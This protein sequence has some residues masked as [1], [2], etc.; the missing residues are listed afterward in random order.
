MLYRYDDML[1]RYGS[2]YQ[3]GRA[4]ASGEI[5]KIARGVYSDE[6]FLDPRSRRVRPLPS[7]GAHYGLGLLP[8]HADRC[9]TRDRAR[10]HAP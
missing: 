9:G 4:V 8:V 1:E 10:C 7:G 3:I 2:A 5:Y 6:R